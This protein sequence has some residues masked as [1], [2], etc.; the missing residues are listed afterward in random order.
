VRRW[1][2]L[3]R[4][5]RE[6][7]RE[8]VLSFATTTW[9]GWDYIPRAWPHWLAADDGVVLV[10]T[11][12]RTADDQAPL[13]AEEVEIEPDRP[14]A[15]AR[16]SMLAPGEAWLE[17]IRVD[18]AMRGLGVATDLQV[19]E[20]HWAAASRAQVVRYATGERNEASHRLGARHGFELHAAFRLWQWHARPPSAE[21][22]DEDDDEDASG[23]DDEA[24]GRANAVRQSVL[25]AL[26]GEGLIA[27]PADADAW[28][29]RVVTDPTFH[30]G[31]E[32]CEH[33]GWAMQR[34]TRPLFDYH[35][36][37]GEVIALGDPAING[38]WALATL[39][40]DAPPAEDADVKLGLLVGDAAAAAGLVDRVRRLA[41]QS[42]GFWLPDSDSLLADGA[43]DRLTELGFHPRPWALHVLARPIDDDHPLPQPD[44]TGS[45]V[46]ATRPAAVRAPTMG[47]QPPG[48]G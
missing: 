20:L 18:P 3:V 43:R 35:L 38:P 44:P 6:S 5:A 28:W 15:V 31:R 26:N 1:P 42:I 2:L 47:G 29:A 48:R 34:L 27:R 11:A 39:H 41:D 37:R 30:A 17:G 7:D 22:D 9:D 25:Q 4:R 14:V 12:G 21:G 19:A 36:A 32:L 8:A 45:L 24:R 33:R 23:F 13:D 46:L 16:M 40:G 10:A